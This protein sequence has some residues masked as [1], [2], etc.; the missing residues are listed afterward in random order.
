V[1]V[2][3]LIYLCVKHVK[4]KDINKNNKDIGKVKKAAIYTVIGFNFDS[5]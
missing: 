3:E 2:R 5:K 4:I 1:E